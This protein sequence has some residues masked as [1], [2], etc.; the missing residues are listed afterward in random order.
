[1]H[2]PVL[3]AVFS[4]RPG[5]AS[6]KT[7]LPCVLL[8]H[9]PCRRGLPAP[10]ER[11]PV[12]APGAWFRDVAFLTGAVSGQFSIP[13]NDVPRGL[14]SL[15]VVPNPPDDNF[16]PSSRRRCPSL[17]HMR[18]KTIY[19]CRSTILLRTAGAA[20]G[21]CSRAAFPAAFQPVHA[22]YEQAEGNPAGVSPGGGADDV[23][24]GTQPVHQRTGQVA[25]GATVGDVPNI[26][27]QSRGHDQDK[28][29]RIGR[30]CSFLVI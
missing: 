7:A 6:R 3:P 19:P 15:P 29:Q 28:T 22:A 13:A 21:R 14:P 9:R 4:I 11:A 16:F 23:D 30:H 18:A 26:G 25:R 2:A 10:P 24:E 8:A 27:T 20:P 12:Q 17:Y 1:M 5:A